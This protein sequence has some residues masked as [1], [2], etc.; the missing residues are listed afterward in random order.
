MVSK[1]STEKVSV[2]DAPHKEPVEYSDDDQLRTC[3]KSASKCKMSG[4]S[5]NT[6][7]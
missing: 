2:G 4:L 3:V 5:L 1:F 7:V 6:S